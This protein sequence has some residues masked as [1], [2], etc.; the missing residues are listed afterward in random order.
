L[1]VKPSNPHQES[2]VRVRASKNGR[3]KGWEAMDW[4]ESLVGKVSS[5]GKKLLNTLLLKF[6]VSEIF[7]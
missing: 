6:E 4:F 7:V 5:Q 3:N 1:R 2:A